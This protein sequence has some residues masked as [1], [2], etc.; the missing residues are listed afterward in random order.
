MCCSIGK[1]HTIFYLIDISDEAMKA[2]IDFVET[3]NQHVNYLIRKD[4]INDEIES[5]SQSMQ[6]MYI[7]SYL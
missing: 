1:H 7:R 4:N 6:S 5:L 2:A 3:C